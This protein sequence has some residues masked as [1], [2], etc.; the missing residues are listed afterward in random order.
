MALTISDAINLE[1][2]NRFNL[3]AGEKGLRNIVTNVGI[4]DHEV[5]TP[6]EFQFGKGEFVLSSFMGARDNIN[7]MIEAIIG[8]INCGASGLAIKT[9]F[10]K[11]L[12]P[13][14]ILL[15]N[16][17]AFPIFL[18]DNSLYYEDIITI[19]KSA[20]REFKDYQVVEGKIDSIL[21]PNTSEATVKKV[22]N[23]IN[24][25]L[26]NNFIAAYIKET[27]YVDDKNIYT[28]LQKLKQFGTQNIITKFKQGILFIYSFEELA[29]I[30]AMGSI[31][32]IINSVCPEKSIY[33]IGVSRMHGTLYKLNSAINESIHAAKINE[34]STVGIT[35]YKNIG[36]NKI[37]LPFLSQSCVIDFYEEIISPLDKYDQ[38]Y[39]AELLNTAI[40]FVEN[41]G[42]IK[43][44]AKV[45]MQH[46]NTVRYRIKKIKEILGMA[47][48]DDTLYEQLLVAVKIHRLLS[49]T[50]QKN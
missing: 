25:H 30:K 41:S 35:F 36:I 33:H 15:A 16:Q 24:P 29:E 46:E 43:A 17:K 12:P 28:S 31:T 37:L 26:T 8:L 32:S 13:E 20:I 10:F 19:F 21:N 5:I 18:F 7:I 45:L 27:N 4:L 1:E 47:T 44:T 48:T 11:E 6:T 38:K 2:I 34:L 42:K 23:E 49:D 50:P 22:A 3:I 40:E 14:V 39:N 9:I